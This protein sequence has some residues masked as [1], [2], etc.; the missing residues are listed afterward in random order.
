MLQGLYLSAQGARVQSLRQEV[1]ANNLANAGTT[2]FKRE[3]VR[4]QAHLPYD[5][6][7]GTSTLNAQGFENLPGGVTPLAP[8]IDLSQGAL[9]QTGSPLD[10]AVSGPGFLQVTDGQ[11]TWLTR[12]GQ[13]AIDAQNRLV[14]RSHGHMVLG[15]SGAPILG[16]DPAQPLTIRPDGTLVQGDTE[17]GQLAVVQPAAPESL[18]RQGRNLL[19]VIGKVAPVN[20]PVAIQQGYLESSGVNPIAGMVDMIESAR[21]FEANATMI[22]TQDETLARLLQSLARR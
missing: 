14:T 16:L 7:R 22:R 2:A 1:L 5:A 6:E 9:Q 18:T 17:V 13:L 12:D 4:A 11:R 15:A 8:A 3:L 21:A 20:G 10:I 19:G